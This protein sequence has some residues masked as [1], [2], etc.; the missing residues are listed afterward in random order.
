MA[1]GL[2]RELPDA[3]D[4]WAEPTAGCRL[5]TVDSY[6]LRLP[7]VAAP[8]GLPTHD[9]PR[10]VQLVRPPGTPGR[11]H[12]ELQ[13]IRDLV[14]VLEMRNSHKRVDPVSAGDERRRLEP[15]ADTAFLHPRHLDA[16]VVDVHQAEQ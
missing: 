3:G 9:A 8:D 4:A 11:Q 5:L 6:R 14:H 16:A 15:R 1:G 7:R 2:R 13:R 12:I 10:D